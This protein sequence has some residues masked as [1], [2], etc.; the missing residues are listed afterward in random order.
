MFCESKKHIVNRTNNA[1]EVIRLNSLMKIPKFWQKAPDPSRYVKETKQNWNSDRDKRKIQTDIGTKWQAT[2]E[3]SFVF[4]VKFTVNQRIRKTGPKTWNKLR[5][6]NKFRLK[7]NEYMSLAWNNTE[8]VPSSPRN[9]SKATTVVSSQKYTQNS[10]PNRGHSGLPK[11]PP[12][13][14][15]N[16]C[17]A[18]PTL[19]KFDN[20]AWI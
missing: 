20:N 7:N 13:S 2:Y 10:Y 12:S 4:K 14:L 19:A 5:F 1:S 15:Q 17:M 8:I 16:I 18:D 3:S 9:I 11:L 6:N